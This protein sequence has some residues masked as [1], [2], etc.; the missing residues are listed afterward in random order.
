LFGDE[1]KNPGVNRRTNSVSNGFMISKDIKD[2]GHLV[3][4]RLRKHNFDLGFEQ[5]PYNNVNAKY[6][7]QF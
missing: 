2:E 4:D 5:L 1:V 3:A 7:E 6:G